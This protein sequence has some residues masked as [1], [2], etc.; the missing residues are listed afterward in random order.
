MQPLPQPHDPLAD[1]RVVHV[2]EPAPAPVL[3]PPLEQPVQGVPPPV[4][5]RHPRKQEPMQ[6][7]TALP[8]AP[9]ARAPPASSPCRSRRRAGAAGR[10]GGR[11]R[12]DRTTENP[13]SSWLTI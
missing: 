7:L 6:H 10:R 4:G 13:F 9:A 11:R 12:R 2:P 1:L 8:T 3:P 5:Q